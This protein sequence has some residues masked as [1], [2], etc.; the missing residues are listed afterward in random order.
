L[1]L[2]PKRVEYF[3]RAEYRGL[4]LLKVEGY[5]RLPLLQTGASGGS[6]P[7]A[8]AFESLQFVGDV[9]PLLRPRCER[10]EVGQVL[11]VYFLQFV[12]VISS[13]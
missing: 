13:R 4:R 5:L 12:E 2:R 7:G 10:F 9:T 3:C 8:L 1:I 6:G 11:S